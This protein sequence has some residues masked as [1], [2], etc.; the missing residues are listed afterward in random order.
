LITINN[1]AGSPAVRIRWVGDSIVD[2]LPGSPA[3]SEG[4]WGTPD[5]PGGFT[6]TVTAMLSAKTGPAAI[7]NQG[8]V[9]PVTGSK[10]IVAGSL[11]SAQPIPTGPA[12]IIKHGQGGSAVFDGSLT[13]NGQWSTFFGTLPPDLIIIA[14][15]I[16]DYTAIYNSTYTAATHLSG[17]NKI[18]DKIHADWPSAQ[19]LCLGCLFVSEEWS[20]SLVGGAGYTGSGAGYHFPPLDGTPFNNNNIVDQ[21]IRSAVSGRSY[22]EYVDQVSNAFAYDQAHTTEPGPPGG[23]GVLS[24]NGLHPKTLCQQLVGNVWL[25]SHLNFV[26]T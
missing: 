12:S 18:L 23:V 2:G 15:A 21:N 6:D 16:N 7:Y 13:T 1:R 4:N 24:L 25:M 17:Y 3:S 9:V 10:V 8:V 5:V 11:A 14:W 20:S 26:T 19:V 22:C